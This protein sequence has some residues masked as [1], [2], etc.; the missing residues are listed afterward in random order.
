MI[1][2]WKVDLVSLEIEH[3]NGL[4]IKKQPDTYDAKGEWVVVSGSCELELLEEAIQYYDHAF[5]K[6]FINHHL[7]KNS[8]DIK[9]IVNITN[10]Y[11]NEKDMNIEKLNEVDVAD[12]MN[13]RKVFPIGTMSL[14]KEA[15]YFYIK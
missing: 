5:S 12:Y 13:D 6:E 8:F 14:I 15:I 9:K 11:I 2:D 10:N 1:N 4:K 7:H 3:S